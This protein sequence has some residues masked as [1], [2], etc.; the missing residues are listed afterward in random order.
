MHV[1]A[2]NMAFSGWL[3]WALATVVA[4]VVRAVATLARLSLKLAVEPLSFVAWLLAD[5]LDYGEW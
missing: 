5:L 3:L 4:D 1:A 2:W